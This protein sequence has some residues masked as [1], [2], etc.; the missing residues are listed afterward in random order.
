[1]RLQVC[2][3]SV[4][5]KRCIR[6]CPKRCCV[7]RRSTRR[8][9]T[10]WPRAW[11]RIRLPV[12]TFPVLPALARRLS[13]RTPYSGSR[14]YTVF[15][16]RVELLLNVIAVLLAAFV[17]TESLASVI[18]VYCFM[19]RTSHVFQ[20]STSTVLC[21]ERVTCSNNLRQLY[22]REELTGDLQSCV[23]GNHRQR[24]HFVDERSVEEIRG[25][26]IYQRRYDVSLT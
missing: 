6:L 2:A 20:W 24:R 23:I 8:S 10:T 15:L 16:T 22:E 25:A 9:T 13:C 21:A 18:Y 4:L 11:T 12:C 7:V 17:W 14:Y 3:T 5:S 19:C 1:M 26:F